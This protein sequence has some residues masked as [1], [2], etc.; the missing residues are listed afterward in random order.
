[1]YV[2]QQPVSISVAFAA[3]T[4]SQSGET[5]FNDSAPGQALEAVAKMMSALETLLSEFLNR[6]G[7][8]RRHWLNLK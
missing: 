3:V 6:A 1:M 7:R 5:F 4:H 8:R 2:Q